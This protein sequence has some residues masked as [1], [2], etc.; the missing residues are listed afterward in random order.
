VRRIAQDAQVWQRL[1][2]GRQDRRQDA[3]RDQRQSERVVQRGEGQVHLDDPH[4]PPRDAEDLGRQRPV[5]AH[6]GYVR[7]LD[8]DIRARRTHGDPYVGL[9]QRRRVVHAV[10]DHHHDVALR[11]VL[12]DDAD[13][14]FGQQL[15]AIRHAD[16]RGQRR[17]GALVV[18]REQLD[19]AHARDRQRRQQCQKHCNDRDPAGNPA[20]IACHSVTGSPARTCCRHPRS[21]GGSRSATCPRRSSSS[22]RWRCLRRC[23]TPVHGRRRPAFRLHRTL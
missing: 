16:L 12:L 11:L 13:L 10:A 17:R 22:R 20:H 9:R 15:G 1:R 21:A 18:A 5:L 7:G 6:E 8:G 19:A 14:V 23:R 2:G 4:R 3:E